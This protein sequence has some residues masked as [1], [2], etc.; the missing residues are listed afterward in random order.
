MT[1]G[2]APAA[3]EPAPYSLTRPQRSS[4]PTT[5]LVLGLI[6]LVANALLIPTIAGIIVGIRGLRVSE[7][8]AA[9]RRSVW[10]IVPSVL[11]I[12]SQVG[13]ILLIRSLAEFQ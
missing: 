2:N 12:I 10:G 11:G 3:P 9:R 4:A 6:S 5:S 7:D 13:F 1:T 8:V